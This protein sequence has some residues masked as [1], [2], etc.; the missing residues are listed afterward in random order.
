MA[1]Q[2]QVI[3][4]VPDQR[5]VRS[6]ERRSASTTV[7]SV[8]RLQRLAGN[9]AA[10]AVL[11]RQ[12]AVDGAIRMAEREMGSHVERE[13]RYSS[14]PDGGIKARHEV[15]EYWRWDSEKR[16]LHKLK[17]VHESQRGVP[18]SYA[19]YPVTKTDAETGRSQPS[20]P[21]RYTQRRQ[22][23]AGSGEA[24]GSFCLGTSR[25]IAVRTIF[26]LD[27]P[28]YRDVL[29]GLRDRIESARKSGATMDEAEALIDRLASHLH[30]PG[31]LA[32]FNADLESRYGITNVEFRS[33][34][35]NAAFTALDAGAP[36]LADLEGGWHWVMV[37]KSPRGRLWKNDPLSGGDGVQ[38]IS[39]NELGARFEIIVDKATGKS[40]TSAQASSYERRMP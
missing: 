15:A 39:A 37:S 9:R 2:R 10:C 27:K 38:P 31:S 26:G 5:P 6:R 33:V 11:A 23:F 7:A 22:S 1:V 12:P 19:R 40:I 30:D 18:L 8:L 34:S 32:Q 25:G 14:Q 13:A 17:A 28:R 35:R 3:R 36:I 21:W 24:A 29:T 4:P 20:S 16:F